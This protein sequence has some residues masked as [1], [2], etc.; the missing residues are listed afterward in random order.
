MNRIEIVFKNIAIPYFQGLLLDYFCWD[1]SPDFPV[2]VYH[3][4]QIRHSKDP[5]S[6]EGT[7]YNFR[8][9]EATGDKDDLFRELAKI[10]PQRYPTHIVVFFQI[11]AMLENEIDTADWTKVEKLAKKIIEK[12]KQFDFEIISVEPQELI[13]IQPPSSLEPWEQIPDARYQLIAK[14]WYDG[15]T[16]QEI[17][18]E[19]RDNYSDILPRTVT[20]IISSLRKEYGEEIVPKQA[21]RDRRLKQLRDSK[22]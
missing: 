1:K 2:C 22:K 5:G 7:P 14:L 12:S 17:A 20:N 13:T 9:V 4:L 8:V 19:V 11:G 16:N 6:V 10:I 3:D 18:K 15:L 21:E